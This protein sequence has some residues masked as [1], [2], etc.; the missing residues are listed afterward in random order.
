MSLRENISRIG[1][2]ESRIFLWIIILSALLVRALWMGDY[3]KTDAFPFT[4]DSDGQAFFWKAQDI[5]EGDLFRKDL[6]TTWPFYV[7]FLAGLLKLFSGNLLRVILIQQLLGVANCVLIYLIG[8]KLFSDTAGFIA[9]MI[10][11]SCSSFLFYE[12]MLMYTSL[13]VFLVSLLF[14]LMLDLPDTFSLRRFLYAGIIFGIAV[15]TQANALIF[16][17]P[18]IVW[19]L[20]R[21]KESL[22]KAARYFFV[23]LAGFLLIIAAQIIRD[24][25]A[26]GTATLGPRNLGVNFFIGNNP[27]ANG[28]M[29]CPQDFANS[30]KGI[31][32]DAK[33]IA[34]GT[35]GRDLNDSE[36]SMFWAAKG[37]DFIFHDTKA[38]FKL[39]CRKM[40]AMFSGEQFAEEH[41][42]RFLGSK[43][44]FRMFDSMRWIL[45]FAVMGMVMSLRMFQRVFLLF[46]VVVVFVF[47]MVLF[48]VMAKYRLTLIPFL[49]IFSGYGIAVFLEALT[50]KRYMILCLFCIAGWRISFFGSRSFRGKRIRSGGIESVAGSRTPH[51][52]GRLS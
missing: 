27:K 46:L 25:I 1:N 48:Y 49:A 28:M 20:W 38:Y 23:F 40:K 45:P 24:S 22:V 15:L 8:R 9:G 10:C 29:F 42:W 16:G 33:A 47:Q 39:I 3:L 6:N 51:A 13:S 14:L 2:K 30:Q 44:R 37:A 36:V 5:V 7:Y 32:R 41:E 17:F 35:L 4:K 11:V 19:V 43:I 31:S 52:T 12:S 21:K 50:R 26:H 34:R 18:A